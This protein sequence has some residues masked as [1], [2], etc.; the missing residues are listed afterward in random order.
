MDVVYTNELWEKRISH[1][2]DYF[3]KDKK[4]KSYLFIYFFGMKPNIVKYFSEIIFYFLKIF[5]EN[6]FLEIILRRNKHTLVV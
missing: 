1:G 6:Y 4:L 5:S 2:M 3:G